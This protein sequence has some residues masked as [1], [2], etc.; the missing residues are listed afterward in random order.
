MMFA[1]PAQIIDHAGNVMYECPDAL[2]SFQLVFFPEL[3]DD[4]IKLYKND[5][6]K[7]DG[8][9][10]LPERA[11]QVPTVLV[12]FN[13]DPKR[14]KPEALR[15]KNIL[16]DFI[17]VEDTP[18]VRE[19]VKRWMSELPKF[20]PQNLVVSVMFTD[21]RFISWKYNDVRKQYERFA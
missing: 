15:G 8:V 5:A 14:L 1:P 13:D 7:I 9:E 18:N 3:N 20:Q 16:F 11:P 17:D 2:T 21:K 12:S 19:A 10:V 6:V 4:V